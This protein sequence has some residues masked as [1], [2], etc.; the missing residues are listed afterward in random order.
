MISG[1]FG[2]P[3]VPWLSSSF[4]DAGFEH[5]ATEHAGGWFQRKSI[6]LICKVVMDHCLP[7]ETPPAG[8]GELWE[9]RAASEG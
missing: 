4:R 9:N 8:A 3:G 6:E 2:L 1:N 5:S 7:P